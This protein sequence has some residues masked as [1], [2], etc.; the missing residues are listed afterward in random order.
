MK[1]IAFVM[2]LI[3]AF[4]A[5]KKEDA[6]QGIIVEP[7]PVKLLAADSLTSGEKWGLK[8]GDT[9]SNL[10]A[11]IP[12]IRP[13]N[14]VQYVNVVG[15]VFTGLNGL[16]SK[17]PLYSAVFLDEA[18]GTGSGIQISFF[19]NKVSAIYTN[20]GKSLNRWPAIA[21]ARAAITRGDAITAVYKKL[22]HIKKMPAYAAKLERISIFTKDVKKAFDPQMSRS[23]QWYFIIRLTGQTYYEVRLNLH[24]G[25]LVSMYVALYQSM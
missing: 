21:P 2:L 4:S 16:E 6:G 5:C 14:P 24:K 17:I 19:N 10:Y 20:A 15:N 11:A 23:P 8:I 25:R 18:R 22:E 9:A 3:A 1:H 12:A 13:E 7:P